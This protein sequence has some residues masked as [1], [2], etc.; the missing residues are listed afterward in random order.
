M[1]E[2]SANAIIRMF[3]VHRRYGAKSAL[4][5]LTLDILKNEYLFVTGASGAGKTTL[6]KLLYLGEAVSEGQTRQHHRARAIARK[7]R[8]LR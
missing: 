2:T 4:H 8:F 5:D 3:H 7:D 1:V 6:L